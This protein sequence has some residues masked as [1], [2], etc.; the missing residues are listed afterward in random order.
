MIEIKIKILKNS[1]LNVSYDY[2]DNTATEEE[3]QIHDELREVIMK[4]LFTKMIDK[5]ELNH[6]FGFSKNNKKRKK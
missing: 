4:T 2:D 5:N 6:E 1:G 3:K